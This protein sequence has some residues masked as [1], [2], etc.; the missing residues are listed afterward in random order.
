MKL[1]FLFQQLI[2]GILDLGYTFIKHCSL[3]IEQS[4]YFSF[5]GACMSSTSAEGESL[6]TYRGVQEHVSLKNWNLALLKSPAMSL[7]V[8]STL[9]T[10]SEILSNYYHYSVSFLHNNLH[11]NN[12]KK[13][14]V[15]VCNIRIR[16]FCV[17]YTGT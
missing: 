16:S 8:F 12:N 15:F 9:C 2:S 1:T 11:F 13:I 17:K 14:N 4:Y 6:C 7:H 5:D 3:T 10:S